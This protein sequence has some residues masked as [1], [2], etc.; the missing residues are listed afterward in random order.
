MFL[1]KNLE[2]RQFLRQTRN[3][4]NNTPSRPVLPLEPNLVDT[5]VMYEFDL[6]PYMDDSMPQSSDVDA[7]PAHVFRGFW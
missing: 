5:D 4:V 1:V 6:E 7:S 3:V 2:L